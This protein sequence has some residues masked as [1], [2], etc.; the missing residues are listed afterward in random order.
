MRLEKAVQVE[1]CWAVSLLAEV[2]FAVGCWSLR[3]SFVFVMRLPVC[4]GGGGRARGRWRRGGG[5]GEL[6]GA[7]FWVCYVAQAVAVCVTQA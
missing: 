5:L 3:H 2:V 1:V 6:L 4:S 7:A